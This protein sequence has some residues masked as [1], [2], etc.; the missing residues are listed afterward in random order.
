MLD[1]C[2]CHEQHRK[3]CHLFPGFLFKA[4]LIAL[5]NRSW[6]YQKLGRLLLLYICAKPFSLIENE[7]KLFLVPKSSGPLLERLPLNSLF[8][9]LNFQQSLLA[10]TSFLRTHLVQEAEG[11]STSEDHLARGTCQVQMLSGLIKSIHRLEQLPLYSPF[12]KYSWTFLKKNRKA[13]YD[14]HFPKAFSRSLNCSATKLGKGRQ[15]EEKLEYT[16]LA[17]LNMSAVSLIIFC[18]T[19]SADT[20]VHTE[21]SPSLS[22]A[23]W[24]N[25]SILRWNQW[26][27][28]NS[29]HRHYT[30]YEQ[31]S[32]WIT[33]A[34]HF[35][36]FR[37][38]TY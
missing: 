1:V 5:K 32:I 6:L 10:S 4:K 17:L 36:E 25:I 35:V 23:A 28:V 20:P 12:I 2:S 15:T 8:H 22:V 19:L 13:I 26:V 14:S 16:L 37:W 38:T 31:K 18:V 27:P 34:K 21:C 7:G 30:S 33:T 29:F 11:I 24:W 9:H 3:G